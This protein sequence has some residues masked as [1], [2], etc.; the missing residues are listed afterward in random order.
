MIAVGAAAEETSTWLEGKGASSSGTTTVAEEEEEA[1]DGASTTG[2]G[3]SAAEP[4]PY[5]GGPAMGTGQASEKQ[6]ASDSRIGY[7]LPELTSQTMPGSS[8]LYYLRVSR[9]KTAGFCDLLRPGRRP[10]HWM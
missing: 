7:S 10:A 3:G 8:T 2:A 4:E 9:T 6:S 5:I 1:L